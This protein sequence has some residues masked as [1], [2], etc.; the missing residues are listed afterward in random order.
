MSL[1]SEILGQIID[2]LSTHDLLKLTL[3]NRTLD[4]HIIPKLYQRI[5]FLSGDIALPSKLTHRFSSTKST[6][7]HNFLKLVQTLRSSPHLR[8]L[9]TNVAFHYSG[10]NSCKERAY[11][12]TTLKLLGPYLKTSHYGPRCDSTM[13][14]GHFVTSL[15][16]SCPR[17]PAKRGWQHVFEMFWAESVRFV[18]L[19]GVERDC[20]L[21][22]V[23]PSDDD[24]KEEEEDDERP[25]PKEYSRTCDVDYLSI[26]DTSVDAVDDIKR[27]M[28]WP[29]ALKVFDYI[30]DAR[31]PE[32]NTDFDSARLIDILSTQ[33]DS[34]GQ[35]SL[36][37]LTK[38]NTTALGIS[39]Q[40]FPK[41]KSLSLSHMFNEYPDRD[42]RY[43][44][45]LYLALPPT[46]VELIVRPS[47][48]VALGDSFAICLDEQPVLDIL[49]HK[50]KLYPGLKRVVIWNY[51]DEKTYIDN[52]PE[53]VI[54]AEKYKSTESEVRGL[55]KMRKQFEEGGVELKFYVCHTRPAFKFARAYV[56]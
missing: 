43:N 33:K 39:L 34:L 41:L 56:Q 38:S 53:D 48:F 24:D 45:A 15:Y 1:P 2:N 50:R 54:V 47:C 25:I 32:S 6:P 27:M 19:R 55:H 21:P 29:K 23:L 11:I 18:S 30:L 13:L 42:A 5:H 40:S 9:I 8:P 46:L 20:T 49:Q 35:I 16:M 44:N 17:A 4:H 26:Q 10:R 7:I 31:N 37:V 3:C 28:Q 51:S 36:D 52:H 22:V 12:L 14:K